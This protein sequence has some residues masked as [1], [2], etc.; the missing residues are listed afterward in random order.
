MR[1]LH[2]TVAAGVF[3]DLGGDDEDLIV[4]ACTDLF[5]GFGRFLAGEDDEDHIHLVL[6]AVTLENG[7]AAVVFF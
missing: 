6:R 5:E 2:H 3:R 7:V 1:L 4:A